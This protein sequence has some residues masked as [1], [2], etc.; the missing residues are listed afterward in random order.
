MALK[1]T[2][3]KTRVELAHVE[4]DHYESL[5]LTLAL[6]PSETPERMMARLLAFCMNAEHPVKFTKGLSETTEPD[7]W[8]HTLD[9]RIALWIDV[10]QPSFDRIKKAVRV[11]QKVKVYPFNAKSGHWWERQREML[12][13]L[14]LSVVR[15]DWEGIRALTGLVKRSMSLSITIS[16]GFIYAASSDGESQIPWSRLQ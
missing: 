8:A 4:Q 2:I 10:G 13:D 14:D 9:D 5:A 6:H 16:D 11:S 15:F 7:I 1:P 3:F 12:K